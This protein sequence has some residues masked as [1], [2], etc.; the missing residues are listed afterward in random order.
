MSSYEKERP[1]FTCI[2]TDYIYHFFASC[3]KQSMAT[4]QCRI[5]DIN[6]TVAGPKYYQYHLEYDSNNRISSITY[7]PNFKRRHF[8]Y[9][10]NY[11]YIAD[12]V[13]IVGASKNKLL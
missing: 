8:S 6:F 2:S 3:T 12:S 5:T 11:I 9:N 1:S 7:S 10:G 13:M 4:S